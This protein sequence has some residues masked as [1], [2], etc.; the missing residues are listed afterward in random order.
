[1]ALPLISILTPCYNSAYLI[2]RLLDSVLA[3]TYPNIEMLVIDDG[4]SDN[5]SEVMDSYTPKFVEKGYALKLIHQENGGQSVAI[6]NGLKMIK[7]DFLV[8][9]DAD[10]WYA[11]ADALEKL[12]AA[13]QQNGDN[14]G[15][16]RCLLN[17]YRDQTFQKVRSFQPTS[18]HFEEDQFEKCLFGQSYWFQPGDYMVKTTTLFENI[19]NGEI[20]TEKR[21]GQNWQLMLPMLYKQ[22]CITVNE[23]LYNVLERTNSH[24]RPVNESFASRVGQIDAYQ[25]TIFSTLDRMVK[26]PDHEREK[27]KRMVEDRYIK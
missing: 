7:G 14:V 20:Y 2:H 9:P 21:A 5:I 15:V 10:D 23:H 3:Q 4:S 16:V 27:Y 11:T 8:W 26:M 1:M 17:Y 18:A 24:S 19:P 12:Y 6:N 25:N 13:F 22:R